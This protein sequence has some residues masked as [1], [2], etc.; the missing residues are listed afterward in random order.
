MALVPAEN[1]TAEC[2]QIFVKKNMQW[3]GRPRMPAEIVWLSVNFSS[4]AN[5]GN[6]N[7]A[8]LG[9]DSI[10]NAVV[11]YAYAVTVRAP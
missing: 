2:V 7:L 6:R 8:I 1:I 11:T 5:S 4:V 9:I 3:F 10:E